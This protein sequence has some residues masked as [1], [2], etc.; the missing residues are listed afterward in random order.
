LDFARE[1][2]RHAQQAQKNLS[3][4]KIILIGRGI[5]IDSLGAC[6]ESRRETLRS[7]TNRAD[8]CLTYQISIYCAK[9]WLVAYL[10][11]EATDIDCTLHAKVRRELSH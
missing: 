8:S 7:T 1:C 2:E 11:F 10:Y 3:E 6:R 5:W 9:V 4:T